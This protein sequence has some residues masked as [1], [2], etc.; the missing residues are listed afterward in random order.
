MPASRPET[1]NKR[2]ITI[3]RANF[4]LPV[5]ANISLRAITGPCYHLMVLN[6]TISNQ[7]LIKF[8][9]FPFMRVNDKDSVHMFF[10]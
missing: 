5:P 6:V 3:V 1:F 2:F 7:D 10:L 9:I 4:A 8:S